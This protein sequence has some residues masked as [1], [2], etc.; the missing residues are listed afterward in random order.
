MATHLQVTVRRP[1][2]VAVHPLAYAIEFVVE[3]GRVLVDRNAAAATHAVHK[4]G[5]IFQTKG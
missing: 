4:S 3:A 1:Q 2:L 5:L